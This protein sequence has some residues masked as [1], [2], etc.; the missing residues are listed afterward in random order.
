MRR[1]PPHVQD[2][3]IAFLRK[4]ARNPR[5]TGALKVRGRDR[6]W[7]IRIGAYRALYKVF[8]DR[9]VIVI[10]K[11]ARRSETTYSL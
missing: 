2:R 9:Q 10:F 8:D 11:V 3:L 7:R 1:L 4:L 5:P 6:T